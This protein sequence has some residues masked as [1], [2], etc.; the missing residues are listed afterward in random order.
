VSYSDTLGRERGL[1]LCCFRTGNDRFGIDTFAVREALGPCELQ[2]IPLAP[3]FVA[4][5]LAYRG[6]V[7]LAVSFRALLG[8]APCAG[9][10]SAIVLRDTETNELFALLVDELMDV[11]RVADNTLEPNPAT[12]D[13]RYSLLFSGVYLTPGLPLARLEPEHV[14]PSWLMRHLGAGVRIGEQR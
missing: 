8:L 3:K 9:A 14:Q 4:G 12:L 10:S 5:M 7:L 6:E 1:N 13:E 2:E 11:I